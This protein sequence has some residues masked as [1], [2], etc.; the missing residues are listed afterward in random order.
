MLACRAG[1]PVL[2]ARIF[3]SY[4]GLGRHRKWPKFG[5]RITI[6]YGELILPMDIDPGGDHDLRYETSAN[7]IMK[8][9][10]RIRLPGSD[11]ACNHAEDAQKKHGA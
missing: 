3:G 11:D 1:V 10:E 9:I 6:V 4:E 7:R 5:Q 2:P 8:A